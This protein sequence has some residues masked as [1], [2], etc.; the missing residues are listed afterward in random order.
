MKKIIF[1]MLVSI[2]ADAGAASNQAVFPWDT[3]QPKVAASKLT[4][5]GGA[6]WV[7]LE[8]SD[9]YTLYVDTHNVRRDG[10]VVQLA[11]LYDLKTIEEAGGKPFR[12][13]TGWADYD[14]DQHLTRIVKA[15]AYSGSMGQSALNSN[16]DP[17]VALGRTGMVNRIAEPGR[18][19]PISDGSAQAV[20]WNYACSK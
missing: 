20:Y 18:W 19:M 12:S 9:R 13:V 6:K 5:Q 2:A 14:C 10:K 7:A 1:A 8:T 3:P 16:N 15:M 17:N 11:T 4:S